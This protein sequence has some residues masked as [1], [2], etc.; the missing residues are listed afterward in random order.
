MDFSLIVYDQITLLDLVGFYDPISRLKTMNFISDLNWHFCAYYPDPK[1]QHGFPLQVDQFRPDLSGYDLVFIPGGFGSRPLLE[2]QSFLAWLRTAE[3]VPLKVSVCTGS[4]LL[5]AANFLNHRR[6][7]THFDE[8]DRLSTYGAEVITDEV[9]VEDQ[10]CITGGAVASSLELGLYL[11]EHLVDKD[12]RRQ[13]KKR[14]G[15]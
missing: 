2:D 9:V 13:I 10:G 6:A 5:G 14:M 8:Y 1:D 12:A 4:L 11:C 7:T 3:P 15:L